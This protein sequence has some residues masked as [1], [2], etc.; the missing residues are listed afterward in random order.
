MLSRKLLKPLSTA[1]LKTVYSQNSN[2]AI[3]S[4]MKEWMP[5]DKAF[6]DLLDLKDASLAKFAWLLA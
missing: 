5:S 2:G 3:S 6:Q 4:S 1:L